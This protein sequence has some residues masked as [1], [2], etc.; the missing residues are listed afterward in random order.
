M[1]CSRPIQKRR[2]GIVNPIQV[3]NNDY[4]NEITPFGCG[5]CLHCRINQS[6]IWQTRLLLE[7]S[8]CFDSTFM[9]LTYDEYNVPFNYYLDKTHLTKFLKRYRKRLGHKIRY[10]AIG[11]YGDETWRP[12]FHL[13]IF[14]EKQ[15]ERCVLSK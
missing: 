3:K 8:D 10:Y 13:A 9:T 12:H 4:R 7:A 5:Q 11:E 2:T 15:L 6:R 14:S 1:I